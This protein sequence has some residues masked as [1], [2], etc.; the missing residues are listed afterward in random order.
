MKRAL[1]NL[2]LALANGFI[3]VFYSERLFWTVWRAGDS[4]ADQ[5]ITWLAYSMAAYLFHAALVYFRANTLWSVSL[6]GAVYGWLI[7]AGSG[8]L[9]RRVHRIPR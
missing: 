5:I 4:V 2:A 1:T 9:Q 8:Y 6:A 3:L 7:E